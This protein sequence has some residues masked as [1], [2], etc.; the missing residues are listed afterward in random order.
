MKKTGKKKLIIILLAVAACIGVSFRI[1]Y[2]NKHARLP[3]Y[4]V[5]ARGESIEKDGFSYAVEDATLYHMSDFEKVYNDGRRYMSGRTDDDLL[6]LV[7]RI[8]LD[9]VG[10]TNTFNVPDNYLEAV[11]VLS[12]VDNDNFAVFNPS[13]ADGTFRSG[14]SLNYV[15][16]LYKENYAAKDWKRIKEL[17]M[18]Y[19]IV[20]SGYPVRASLDVGT[21]SWYR[22]SD[23]GKE[24]GGK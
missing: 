22:A 7:V 17:R 10:D 19:D 1:I 12:M 15:F 14:G 9:V 5:Y 6:I 23:A 2:V 16:C 24:Q 13:L 3:E 8:R 20:Y 4:K 21:V 18:D 11:D